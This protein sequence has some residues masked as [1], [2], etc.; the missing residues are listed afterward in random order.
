[1]DS[2]DDTPHRGGLPHS[3]TPGSK[4]ACQLPEAYRRLPRPSSPVIAKAS[5]TCSCSLDP[6]ALLA[7][8]GRRTHHSSSVTATVQPCAAH[9]PR[10]LSIVLRRHPHMG[11][12]C[13]SPSWSCSSTTHPR[14]PAAGLAPHLEP[15]K[16]AAARA[17]TSIFALQQPRAPR[18][19]AP[20][21]HSR[22]SAQRCCLR[23]DSMHC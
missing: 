20:Q 6:I 10:D 11:R 7:T 4:L 21:G 23:F 13:R 18:S 2:V 16:R 1:M 17:V 19:A 14:G 9:E 22:R 12:R 15:H 3:E 8:S 5:T